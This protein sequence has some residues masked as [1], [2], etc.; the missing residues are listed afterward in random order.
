MYAS[1]RF[2]D[3]PAIANTDGPVTGVSA[4]YRF[5][6]T[7]EIIDALDAEGFSVVKATQGRARTAYAQHRVD[8]EHKSFQPFEVRPNDTVK[9]RVVLINS[10]NK[11][12]GFAIHAGA[13]RDVCANGMVFGSIHTESVSARHIG[14]G[15][16]IEGVYRIVDEAQNV[17]TDMR[18]MAQIPFSPDQQLEFAERALTLRWP[19]PHRPVEPATLIQPRRMGDV[20]DNLFLTYQRVQEALTRGGMAGRTQTNRVRSVRALASIAADFKVNNGLYQLA[21]EYSAAA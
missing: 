19:G 9:M 16:I 13:F 20:G 3:F 14:T 12:S 8:L 15:D 2:D 1:Q 10:H 4:R 18:D 7:V 5:I 11:R 6:P 21:Q 17:L